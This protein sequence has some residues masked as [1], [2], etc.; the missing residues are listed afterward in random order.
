[1]MSDIISPDWLLQR[2]RAQPLPNLVAQFI[3]DAIRQGKLNPGQ[4]LPGENELAD[5]LGVSRTTLRA[6]VQMLLTQGVLERQH[7]VGTF[8]ANSSLLMIEEGLD[9]LISTTELI[10]QHGYEPGTTELHS[11]VVIASSELCTILNLPQGAPLLHISRTRTA[12]RR[13]VI[14]AEEYVPTAILDPAALPLRR[15]DW[16]LYELLKS[17]GTP[18]ESAVTKLKAVSA[19][20]RLARAL[21][22]PAKSPLLLLRQTHFASGHRPILYCENYHNTAI[23]EFQILRRG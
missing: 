8:V 13:P 17:S 16:S 12:N 6:A 1:M 7:G 22:V 10:R 4:R 20:A 19:D 5:Q 23:I 11:E 15:K 14:Q 9:A 2:Q 3:R 21:K 18:I